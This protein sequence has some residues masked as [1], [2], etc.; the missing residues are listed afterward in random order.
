M[1]GRGAGMLYV[2]EE[3]GQRRGGE[4]GCRKEAGW[5][6]GWGARLCVCTCAC[7]HGRECEVRQG[8]GKLERGTGWEKS[9]QG[10]QRNG[11]QRGRWRG[12][13]KKPH[14]GGETPWGRTMGERHPPIPLQV[15]PAIPSPP[16]CWV[17]S[18]APSQNTPGTL[19]RTSLA[20]SPSCPPRSTPPTSIPTLWPVPWATC[21]QQ[22]Q[23]EAPPQHPYWL[24]LGRA[25]APNAPRAW[26]RL[27]AWR[28]RGALRAQRPR[29]VGRRTATQSWRSRTS[30]AAALTVRAMRA[31]LR[32]PRPRRAKGGL[33][34]EPASG[35]GFC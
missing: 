33:A 2:R 3:G 8:G 6:W 26:Q 15:P 1:L 9:F 11:R 13:G 7:A 30:V 27:L 29:W 10:R 23:G 25:W 20:P 22:G 5:G 16:A 21:Q 18:A 4:T 34:A 24:P 31:S 14:E 28:W 12:W 19:A 17:P 32:P 35:D